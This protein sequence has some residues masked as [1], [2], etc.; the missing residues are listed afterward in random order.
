M[1][2]LAVQRIRD[3]Y[4][5]FAGDLANALKDL[6]P[7]AVFQFNGTGPNSG[8]HTGAEE[9]TKALTATFELT[10]DT[11]KL[12]IASTFADDHH[13]VVVMRE[14][15]SRPDGGTLDVNEVHAPAINS[16]GQITDL[17]DLPADPRATRQLLRR[18]IAWLGLRCRGQPR[19]DGTGDRRPTR[20]RTFDFGRTGPSSPTES[21]LWT[22][23]GPARSVR[24][25]RP[26][27][28]GVGAS[29]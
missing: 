3:A 11:Q 18:Q 2:R 20:C 14:T 25:L 24:P 1:R 22:M 28:S 7:N 29:A 6:A 19:P 21:A 16:D 12:D 4:A 5:A 10:G 27:V 8:D 9:I 23:V 15:A 13:G 17:W 26:V